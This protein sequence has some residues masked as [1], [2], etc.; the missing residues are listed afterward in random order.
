M[1]LQVKEGEKGKGGVVGGVKVWVRGR[2]GW[3]E[4]GRFSGNKG[5]VKRCAA[6][7][8]I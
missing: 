8:T 5:K 4:S 1:E 6:H 2:W 7:D 3:R